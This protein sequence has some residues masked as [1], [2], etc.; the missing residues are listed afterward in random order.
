[1]SNKS[2]KHND[3]LHAKSEIN[4]NITWVMLNKNNKHNGNLHPKSEININV[5]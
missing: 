3:N 2:N 5:T 4:I 1:M